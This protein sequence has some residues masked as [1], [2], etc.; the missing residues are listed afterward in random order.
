MS[1]DVSTPAFP[2]QELNS[3]GTPSAFGLSP[4]LTKREY[5]AAMAMQGMMPFNWHKEYKD[6]ALAAFAMADAMIAEGNKQ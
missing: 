6:V 4:G 5:F 3:D 2:I 1:K